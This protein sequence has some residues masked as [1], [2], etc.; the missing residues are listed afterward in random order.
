MT[1]AAVVSHSGTKPNRLNHQK[2]NRAAHHRT[3]DN[4]PRIVSPDVHARVGDQRAEAQVKDI[5]A[6]ADHEEL[7]IP[8]KASTAA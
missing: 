2:G 6:S 4:V 5:Q 3:A 8:T 1:S 7:S